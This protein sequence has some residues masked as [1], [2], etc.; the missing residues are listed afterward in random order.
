M[1]NQNQQTSKSPTSVKSQVMQGSAAVS[2]VNETSASSSVN[3]SM[4][5]K[6][7]ASNVQNNLSTAKFDANTGYE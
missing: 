6:Q 1:K 2:Q 7:K 3:Q 5:S 4:S